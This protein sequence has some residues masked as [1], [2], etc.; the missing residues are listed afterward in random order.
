MKL[1]AQVVK[2][3]IIWFLFCGGW[4]HQDALAL[5]RNGFDLTKSAIPREEIISGGP[6]K[7]GIPALD[8]PKFVRPD[9][10]TFLRDEDIVISVTSDGETKAYAVRILNWHEVVNDT[11]GKK[12][13]LIT[14]CPLCGT[15]IVFDRHIDGNILTF[16]VSGLLYQSDVL[17]YDRFTESLWS[18][19]GMKAVTGPMSGKG[20][21]WLPSEHLTWAAWREAHPQGKV[22]SAETGYQRDYSSDPYSGYARSR[23]TMFPVRWTRLELDK[24]AWIVGVIVNGEAK[25]YPMATLAQTGPFEDHVAGMALRVSYDWAKK[26]PNIRVAGTDEP[27]SNTMAYWFAWQ[28]FYPASKIYRPS[29]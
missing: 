2:A 9:Q 7:D 24:K 18:Q 8:Q 28:A 20:L 5:E 3:G 25:A 12:P 14:Y 4:T 26:Q 27:V 1:I 11:V 22:L 16:G 21:R 17:L 15:G 10:A 23:E 6:P 29:Q 19:L 13:V